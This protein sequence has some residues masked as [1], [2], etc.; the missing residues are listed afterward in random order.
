MK[1]EISLAPVLPLCGGQRS[2]PLIVICSPKAD[3]KCIFG[4]IYTH[5]VNLHPSEGATDVLDKS[6]NQSIQ[7]FTFSQI[8]FSLTVKLQ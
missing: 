2:T 4:L 7:A 3:V 8:V 5:I 1:C 6:I